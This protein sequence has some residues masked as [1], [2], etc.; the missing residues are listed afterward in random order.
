MSGGVELAGYFS[1]EPGCIYAQFRYGRGFP[2]AGFQHGAD[3]TQPFRRRPILA[4]DGHIVADPQTQTVIVDRDQI[5]SYQLLD[6]RF[7]NQ[8]RIRVG[9]CAV[10]DAVN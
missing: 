4:F 2:E 3:I 6:Q 1:G 9:S 8:A 7:F 10:D 5:V